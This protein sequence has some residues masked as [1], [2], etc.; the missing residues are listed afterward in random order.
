[1]SGEIRG[2]AHAKNG[3]DIVFCNVLDCEAFITVELCPT[4]FAALNEKCANSF[5]TINTAIFES[6]TES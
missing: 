2:E 3:F 4:R 1:M 5:R 6:P